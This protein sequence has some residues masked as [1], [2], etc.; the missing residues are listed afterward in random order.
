MSRGP[1]GQQEARTKTCRQ[2][3]TW[4][5]ALI[6]CRAVS[7]HSQ[8]HAADTDRTG[9][10]YVRPRLASGKCAAL[11]RV[12]TERNAP[13]MHRIRFVASALPVAAK[14]AIPWPVNQQGAVAQCASWPGCK[15]V[16][17]WCVAHVKLMVKHMWRETRLEAGR[18]LSGNPTAPPEPPPHKHRHQTPT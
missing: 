8:Q 14:I 1:T 4:M 6:A 18:G 7:P 9:R 15:T 17:K 16:Q 3:P 12:A 13:H 2:K 5:N 11:R 10:T